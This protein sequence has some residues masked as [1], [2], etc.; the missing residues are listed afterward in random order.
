M[1]IFFRGSNRVDFGVD[2]IDIKRKLLAALGNDVLLQVEF[3]GARSGAAGAL[4]G[5]DIELTLTA[6]SEQPAVAT[7]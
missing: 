6:K 2:Q 3:A 4:N 1:L 7:L 5:K